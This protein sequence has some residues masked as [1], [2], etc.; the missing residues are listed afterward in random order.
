MFVD[1]SANSPGVDGMMCEG[2][3]RGLKKS[4]SNEDDSSGSVEAGPGSWK[5][6][7]KSDKAGSAAAGSG[8]DTACTRSPA[9]SISLG[10]LGR[11]QSHSVS[12]RRRFPERDGG[13]S[14]RVVEPI[15]FVCIRGGEWWILRICQ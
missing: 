3:D 14:V 2:S 4:R 9:P 10:R 8:S 15:S 5:D 11:G 7:S 6:R 13:V 12:E 1:F